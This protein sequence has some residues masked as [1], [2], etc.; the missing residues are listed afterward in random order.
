LLSIPI[1]RYVTLASVKRHAIHSE[2]PG[3]KTLSNEDVGEKFFVKSLAFQFVGIGIGV[4]ACVLITSSLISLLPFA[5]TPAPEDINYSVIFGVVLSMVA[6]SRVGLCFY[7]VSIV[8][9]R[10]PIQE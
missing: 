7:R 8:T 3:E 10:L 6:T 4:I 2:T 5:W 1:A 9:R